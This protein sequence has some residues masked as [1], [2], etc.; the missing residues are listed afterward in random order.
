MP[1]V[2]PALRLFMVFM[3]VYDTYK[4]LKIP[5]GRKG[6]PPSIKTMTQRKRDLKGCLAVWVV[7]CC[8]AA[9]ERTFDRFVS[10]IVPFYSEIKSVMLVF[11]LLTRAKGAEPLYLHILRPLIKPYV[12]TL[13]P[14]LD[15]AR[16]I[17]DFLFALSQVPLNY[18]LSLCSGLPWHTEENESAA[19]LS[20]NTSESSTTRSS[21]DSS[22]P[23]AAK[24]YPTADSN[25]RV[26]EKRSA[27]VRSV[28]DNRVRPKSRQPT[29]DSYESMS[30]RM[31]HSKSS[32]MTTLPHYPNNTVGRIHAR[33]AVSNTRTAAYQIWHPPPPAYEEGHRRSRSSIGRSETVNASTPN[34]LTPPPAVFVSEPTDEDWRGYPPFPS[35]YP[36]TPL[37]ASHSLGATPFGQDNSIHSPSAQVTVISPIPEDTLMNHS[38]DFDVSLPQAH[39]PASPGS[40]SCSSDENISLRVHPSIDGFPSFGGVGS[41][42][43]SEDAYMDDDDD[44]DVTL[45]T[46]YRSYPSSVASNASS[47]VASLPSALTT[48]D[49]SSLRTSSS[50]ESTR[51]FH[52]SDSSHYAG[53]KRPYPTVT[54]TSR[55]T[56]VGAMPRN[57]TMR[58]KATTT[59]PSYE[60]DLDSGPSETDDDSD[61][62]DGEDSGAKRRKVLEPTRRTTYLRPT[63]KP[64][65]NVRKPPLTTRNLPVSTRGKISAPAPNSGTRGSSRIAPQTVGVASRGGTLRGQTRRSTLKLPSQDAGTYPRTATARNKT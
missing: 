13:D 61:D 48:T 53:Q 32:S 54:M 44:F 3:N 9:Y 31:R 1:L 38:Q 11:L 39:E 56:A 57:T 37:T 33:P 15:L 5:P 46:P 43:E 58:G 40:S 30:L 29:V 49:A 6:G 20:E 51:T 42:D 22:I 7:W 52:S 24:T 8:L 64:T 19:D 17:G 59:A 45:R 65:T 60:N 4:T 50:S 27:T 36:P 14:L 41:Q 16:D 23:I 55:T 26:A 21:S 10:F 63:A 62:S 25:P 47:S 35:A 18:V 12:D 34:L 2:V 28:S